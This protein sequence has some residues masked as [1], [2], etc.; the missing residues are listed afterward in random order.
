MAKADMRVQRSAANV[1]PKMLVT[2]LN[3]ESKSNYQSTSFTTT[4][5]LLL[6]TLLLS[7]LN[8]ADC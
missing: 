3:A 8:L 6:L 5:C 2:H 4:K 1:E 7:Q